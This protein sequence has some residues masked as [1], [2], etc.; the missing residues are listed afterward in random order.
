MKRRAKLFRYGKH[1]FKVMEQLVPE[2][3]RDPSISDEDF[4]K[5]ILNQDVKDALI[6]GL[7]IPDTKTML[8]RMYH[9]TIQEQVSRLKS[10]IVDL[11]D[12]D[13]RKHC[14]GVDNEDINKLLLEWQLQQVVR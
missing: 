13:K 11:G 14:H 12:P 5:N 6:A 3:L 10:Y 1:A 2:L 9:G 8:K 4:A 7:S